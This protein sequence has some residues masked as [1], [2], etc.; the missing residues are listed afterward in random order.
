MTTKICSKCN[1]EK[2][3]SEFH[4]SKSRADGY[5]MVCKE[6]RKESSKEYY[7][8]NKD[9]IKKRVKNYQENNK[10]LISTRK[11]KYRKK[12]FEENKEQANEY[13]R[14]YYQKNKE[15][16]SVQKKPYKKKYREENKKKIKEYSISYYEKNKKLINEKKKIYRKENSEMW[17]SHSKEYHK[18][19]RE[20]ILKKK[21]KFYKEHREELIR[22][23]V[24]YK[25]SN[26]DKVRL[27][28][29]KRRATIR[30]LPN[31]LTKA[32][33]EDIKMLFD[34]RCCYCGEPKLLTQEHFIPL[35]KGGGYTSSNII[36]SC[37]SCNS[38][39]RDK[40]FFKWYPKHFSYSQERMD[41]ILKH[42]E[43]FASG[44]TNH[45]W[46]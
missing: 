45:C 29:H 42:L 6:C 17:K 16:I 41:A 21:R 24:E 25:K 27:S 46:K 28:G 12:H 2:L 13:A 11:K 26:K 3:V 4:K 20:A 38:S 14:N 9:I 34:N 30:N 10:E 23:S 7:K 32:Q 31:D 37:L 35:S 5:K 8:E 22:Q 15:K 40:N 39:K 44:K 18:K 36:P 33:W 1:T 19:N 43:E